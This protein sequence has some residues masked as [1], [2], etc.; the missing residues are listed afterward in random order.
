M[1]TALHTHY[2][3]PAQ[4]ESRIERVWLQEISTREEK[5]FSVVLGPISC[6]VEGPRQRNLDP[7]CTMVS[8]TPPYGQNNQHHP[9]ACWGRRKEA[10]LDLYARNLPS[11]VRFQNFL[12]SAVDGTPMHPLTLL[13]DGEHFFWP[14]WC[15]L[16]RLLLTTQ[17][18]PSVSNDSSN[19]AIV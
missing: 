6:P 9:G 19:A 12:S 18:P 11:W 13:D 5:L 14:K 4:I 7:R 16:F 17:C 10:V 1:M 3:G 15:E 8:S 2:L